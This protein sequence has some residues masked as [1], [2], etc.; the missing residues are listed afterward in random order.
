MRTPGLPL[1]LGPSWTALVVAGGLAVLAAPVCTLLVPAV[2]PGSLLAQLGYLISVGFSAVFLCVAAFRVP[3]EHRR[4]WTILMWMMAL[5]LVA[6]TWTAVLEIRGDEQW[7]TGA[8]VL[9]IAG[10]VMMGCAVMALVRQR[11]DRPAFGSLLDAGIVTT[12]V[13]VL[14]LVFVIGPAAADSTQSVAARVVGSAYPLI[15]VLITFLVAR[16]LIG[17]RRDAAL[18][19]VAAG[20]V[21]SLV[22]DTLQN[23]MVLTSSSAQSPSYMN[24]LWAFYYATLGLAAVFARSG[25][26]APAEPQPQTGLTMLR[27]VVLAVGAAT[28]AIVQV[29]LAALGRPE[30]GAQL[31]AGS[32]LLLVMVLARIW[33]L[34]HQVREQSDQMAEMARTDP[35]TGVANRRSWD[36]EL[37]RARVASARMGAVL[38]VALLDLDHFKKYNDEHGHQAGDDLLRQA[39]QAWSRRV[40]PGGLIARWGGEEFAVALHSADRARGLQMVHALREL[41]PYGQTCSIGVAEWDGTEDMVTLLKRADDALYQAKRSGRDRVVPAAADAGRHTRASA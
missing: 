27:L 39:A 26:G 6:E 36:F 34:L 13:G 28:P 9:F 14:A 3:R 16:I 10:Y 5:S 20:L 22:A 23:V 35:L 24:L 25:S 32:L 40:E 30:N 11:N 37:E 17:S 2:M 21:A 31:G 18:W 41:V 1:A 38:L 7:P 33:D 15:D 19:W 12:G 4:P 29:V 8:D